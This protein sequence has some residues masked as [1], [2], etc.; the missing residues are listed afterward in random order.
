MQNVPFNRQR[1]L[2]FWMF[3]QWRYPFFTVDA[4]EPPLPLRFFSSIQID[5]YLDA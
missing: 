5:M 2:P 4:Q 3:I 1:D